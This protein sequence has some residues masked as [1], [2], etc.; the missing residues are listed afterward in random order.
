MILVCGTGRS[1]TLTW[2]RYLAAAGV[3]S[4]HEPNADLIMLATPYWLAGGMGDSQHTAWLDSVQWP[5]GSAFFMYAA[6]IQPLDRLKMPQWIW[7]QRDPY[8]TVAS[9]LHNNWYD[10]ELDSRWPVLFSWPNLEAGGAVM[11]NTPRWAYRPAAWMVGEMTGRQ[12]LNLPQIERCAWWVGWASRQMRTKLPPGRTLITDLEADHN[13][14]LRKLGLP[15]VKR[16][17][18]NS[19]P[20]GGL[21]DGQRSIVT[22]YL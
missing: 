4:A 6:M 8:D 15:P 14:V 17:R 7:V 3:Q 11:V 16:W 9:M 18:R 21:D 2:A 5:A 20:H 19:T 10:P 1:G 13:P 12:W 22:G